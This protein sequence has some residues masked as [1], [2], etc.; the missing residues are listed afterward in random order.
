MCTGLS[1]IAES[2]DAIRSSNVLN[3]EPD[4]YLPTKADRDSLQP[5]RTEQNNDKS[6]I[7]F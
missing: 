6:E 1:T 3:N 7:N 4:N 2:M 5:S